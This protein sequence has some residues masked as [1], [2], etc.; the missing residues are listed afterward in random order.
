[1]KVFRG[2]FW[3]FLSVSV[4][5]SL[6]SSFTVDGGELAINSELRADSVTVGK[7]A[8]LTGT[9]L[10]GGELLVMG[11]VAPGVAPDQSGTLRIDG[12]VI[13]YRDAVF[14]C[15]V[16]SHSLLDRLIAS[17][18]VTGAGT[19]IPNRSPGAIPIQETVISGDT[20]SSGLYDYSVGGAGAP[21][22]SVTEGSGLLQLTYLP[23]DSDLDGMPDYWEWKFFLDRI[24]GDPDGH[25]DSD[26]TRNL[27]EFVAN[28]NPL[29]SNS[30]FRIISI[31][32][33]PDAQITWTSSDDCLY[34][35]ARSTNLVAG[36]GFVPIGSEV[37]ATPP[38]NSMVDTNETQQFY[39]RVSVRRE[40]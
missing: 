13:F 27:D 4:I 32:R 8:R 1:M 26:G 19:V 25:S 20:N 10:V 36:A 40:N 31:E 2:F 35:L 23:G 6:A 14:E 21:D 3:L 30:V 11:T 22:W 37:S 17:G 34:T 7:T 29:D 18:P 24:A 5:E 12:G 33:L 15:D 9:G 16:I 39:Y 38:F 28:T